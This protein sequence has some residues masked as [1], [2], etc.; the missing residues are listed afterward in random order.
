MPNH[1]HLLVTPHVSLSKLLA[2]LKGATARR[3]NLL[4]G[5]TGERFWQDESYDHLVRTEEE[6]QRIAW[7]I[8]SNPVMAG[9]A[10]RAEDYEWSSAG[11]LG[12]R[13]LE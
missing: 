9:L 1:V 3:A 2:S 13:R 4:L 7:Y 8:E 6:L 5:R 11:Q 10:A 12:K